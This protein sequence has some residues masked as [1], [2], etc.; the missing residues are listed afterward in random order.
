MKN[1]KSVLDRVIRSAAFL[2]VASAIAS[3]GG[4]AEVV[5]PVVLR[6]AEVDQA[7]QRDVLVLTDQSLDVVD[8]SLIAL[9]LTLPEFWSRRWHLWVG[10]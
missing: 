7:L 5:A 1:M 2:M 6:V 8:A 9:Q 10:P 4:G 3:R